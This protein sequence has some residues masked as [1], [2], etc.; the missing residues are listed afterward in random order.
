MTRTHEIQHRQVADLVP[1]AYNARTHSPAQVAQIAAS[2][3]EFGF[4]NPVLIAPDSTLIAGHGRVLAARQLGLA[5]VPCIVLDGL[6]DAQLR[7]YV[8]AD[9]KLALNA[10]WDDALLAQE[11][12]ALE[13]EGF[14]LALTGFAQADLDS[15]L[16]KGAGDTGGA[17]DGGID[18]Q[19]RFAV[20]VECA[21]EA[22]QAEIYERLTGL[23]LSCKVLV[24]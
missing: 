4:T 18:Y 13:A 1:Y 14:D 8:L 23:G 10:G 17:D 6:T 5:T 19:E 15:L 24:N 11:L 20:V 7:A 9:N 22:D 16:G 12:Q 2:I 21:D 3:G